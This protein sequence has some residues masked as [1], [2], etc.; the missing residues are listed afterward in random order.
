MDSDKDRSEMGVLDHLEELRWRII[1]IIIAILAGG[2]IVFWFIDLILEI[3]LYP[4]S[5]TT[6]VNPIRL[7]VLSVQGMFLIKWTIAIIGGIIIAIP[8]ITYQCWK[9]IAPGLYADEKRFALPFTLFS[10][11]S[12]IIG[13]LLGYFVL[14]PYSLNFFSG[15]TSG[16]IENNFSINYYFSFIVWILLGTGLIF[17]LPVISLLLSIIGLLT[18]SFMRHYRRHSIIVILVMASLITPPDPVSMVIMAI[19]LVLLYEAS[20]GISWIINRRTA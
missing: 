4:I 19:P 18:P 17:Q 5:R 1:K 16:G 11:I 2:L 3:M 14:I 12:F 6:S 13:I 8:V 7:Q 9:F 20:I 15:L 10:F